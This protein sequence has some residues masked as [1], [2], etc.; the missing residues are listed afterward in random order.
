MINIVLLLLLLVPS[1]LL[2][3]HYCPSTIRFLMNWTTFLIFLSFSFKAFMNVSSF[4]EINGINHRD[5]FFLKGVREQLVGEERLLLFFF[6]FLLLISFLLLLHL[7]ASLLGTSDSQPALF[8]LQVIIKVKEP[9]AL[10]GAGANGSTL[11]G[12]GGVAWGVQLTHPPHVFKPEWQ[13]YCT[14]ID[15]IIILIISS[16]IIKSNATV[17]T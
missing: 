3:Y 15:V 9:W 11:Q 14:S 8:S 16:R 10:G 17:Q 1:L 12:G 5:Y 6:L 13:C 4:M 7:S 2:L